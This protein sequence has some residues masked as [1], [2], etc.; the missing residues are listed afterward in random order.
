MKDTSMKASLR[1][2][3]KKKCKTVAPTRRETADNVA[4]EEYYDNDF[5]TGEGCES[6]KT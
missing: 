5:G 4:L 6:R 1:N 2:V 3:Q